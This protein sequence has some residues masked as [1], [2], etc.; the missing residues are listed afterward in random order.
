MSQ[1][2]PGIDSD[3]LFAEWQLESPRVNESRAKAAA[4]AAEIPPA[5]ARRRPL[6][7]RLTGPDYVEENPGQ[8]KQEQLRVAAE[9]QTGVCRRLGCRGIRA[10]S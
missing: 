6:K 4:G 8:A 5:R 1:R 9:F 10:F 3:R 2:G 7:F